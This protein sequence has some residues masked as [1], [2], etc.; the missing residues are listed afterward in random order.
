LYSIEIRS[1]I[2]QSAQH[3]VAR[4]AAGTIQIGCFHRSIVLSHGIPPH[5][6]SCDFVA[7]IAR[8][9]PRE[10]AKNEALEPV[11]IRLDRLWPMPYSPASQ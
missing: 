4:Q 5:E 3:H 9:A 7:G 8:C 1:G 2:D 6:R 11:K 10:L